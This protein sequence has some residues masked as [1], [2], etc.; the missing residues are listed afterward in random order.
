MKVLFK[1]ANNSGICLQFA[2]SLQDARYIDIDIDTLNSFNTV[3][4]ILS[5]HGKDLYE[6]VVNT[7]NRYNIPTIGFGLLR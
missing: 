6:T 7:I 4:D 5:S 3:R 1:V 2:G